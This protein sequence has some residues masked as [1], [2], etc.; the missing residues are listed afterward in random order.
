M[1]GNNYKRGP[2]KSYTQEEKAKAVQLLLEQE[3]PVTEISRKLQIPCKNIKRWSTQGVYRKT[4]GGR[5]RSS[6]KMEQ[7]IKKWMLQQFA[8]GEVVE[9]DR[10]REY[11]LAI[12]GDPAFKASRGWACKFIDRA[13]LRDRYTFR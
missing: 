4:G 11:A 6:P 7:D 8:E 5:K 10:I 12:S 2:Y 1:S 3:L 9:V 13:E